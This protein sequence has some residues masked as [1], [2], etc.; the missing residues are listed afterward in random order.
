MVSTLTA[1]F[2]YQS[3]FPAIQIVLVLFPTSVC[4]YHECE[5]VTSLTD[6]DVRFLVVLHVVITVQSCKFINLFTVEGKNVDQKLSLLREQ[7]E[8]WVAQEMS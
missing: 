5:K 1:K 8:L 2:N 3:N 6:M 4:A 7:E